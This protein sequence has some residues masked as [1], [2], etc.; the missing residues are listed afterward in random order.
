MA[1]KD[2]AQNLRHAESL[3]T[4]DDIATLNNLAEGLGQRLQ[5]TLSFLTKK[6]DAQAGHAGPVALAKQKRKDATGRIL[7]GMVAQDQRITQVAP[8]EDDDDVVTLRQLRAALTCVN[9]SN[10]L[11]DCID[12]MPAVG[13]QKPACRPISFS[14]PREISTGLSVQYAVEAQQEFVYV[15]GE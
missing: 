13:N 15:L 4:G 10:I 8:A 1:D 11:N 5:S 12:D 6:G 7:P 2:E 9:L 14:T 3:L